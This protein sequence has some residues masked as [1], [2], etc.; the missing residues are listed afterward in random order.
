MTELLAVVAGIGIQSLGEDV[1]SGNLLFRVAPG[2]DQSRAFCL[3]LSKEGALGVARDFTIAAMGP[4]YK[5]P[6]PGD[7]IN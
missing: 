3:S 5:G 7:T 6:L 4:D 1:L 2:G